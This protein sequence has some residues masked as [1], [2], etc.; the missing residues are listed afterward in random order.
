MATG[1]LEQLIARDEIR[2]LVARYAVAVDSRDLDTLVGLFVDDVQVGRDTFGHEALRRSFRASLSAVGVTILQV[3]THV[4]DLTDADHATGIVY[5][6]G[7]VQE[8]DRWIHQSILYRDTYERR[9]GTWRFVR[10]VHEL[11]HGTVAADNPMDQDPANWPIRSFG[12]G[13]APD[14]FPTWGPFWSEIEG[15]TDSME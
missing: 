13:T 1:P 10:R 5:C 6:S 7:Q 14:S 3:G 2:Q 4:I 8:G 11:F 12:T 9:D 15:D